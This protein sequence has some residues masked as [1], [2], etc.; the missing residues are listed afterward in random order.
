[1]VILWPRFRHILDL[2]VASV[3]DTDPSKLGSVDT[4]PHY[5]RATHLISR[6]PIKSS[7]INVAINS[8]YICRWLVSR[9][10]HLHNILDIPTIYS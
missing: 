6:Y 5:V 10:V 4:R 9:S 1:M 7:I 3:R 8:D 2:N